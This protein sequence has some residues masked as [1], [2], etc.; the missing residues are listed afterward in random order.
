MALSSCA[1]PS[2]TR[3]DSPDKVYDRLA[4]VPPYHKPPPEVPYSSDSSLLSDRVEEALRL[5]DTDRWEHFVDALDPGE[6]IE[7]LHVEQSAID[8]GEWKKEW[9]FQNGDDIF[10]HEIGPGEGFGPGHFR[11]HRPLFGGPDATGCSECHHR[12]GFNGS[13]DLSQNAFF[14]GDGSDPKSAFER[15]PPAVLGLGIEQRLAEEMTLELQSQRQNAIDNTRRY[16]SASI[17]YLGSHGVRFG[18]ITIL[19]GGAQD[20]SQ[21]EGIDPDLVVKPF[22]WKGNFASLR[23][24]VIGGFQAHFGIQA[25]SRVDA[26]GPGPAWDRDNDGVPNEIGDGQITTVVLYLSRL[27]V[28]VILPPREPS[29][30]ARHGHGFEVFKQIGCVTCHIPS[31]PLGDPKLKISDGLTTNVLLEGEGPR[32]RMDVYGTGAAGIPIFLFSDLKR[33]SMGK[34]LAENR[35]TEESI[36][37]YDPSTHSQESKVSIP[38]DTFLTRPLWGLADTAP[39]LHDGRARTLDEAILAHG[40]EAADSSSRFAALSRDDKIDLRI[41]LL[42]LSRY[43]RIDYR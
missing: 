19:P 17:H 38:A 26:P 1:S 20:N 35:A 25:A 3:A 43:P 24:F 30:L 13:G 36:N 27:E 11:V 2:S 6:L 7:D 39:Y 10:E 40:G 34:A 33:H 21:L 32:P 31:L 5:Y 41:F 12:G 29:L 15:N 16:K 4:D 37:L 28:P 18:A 8:R 14:E 23:Q 9:L 42:S 22:G